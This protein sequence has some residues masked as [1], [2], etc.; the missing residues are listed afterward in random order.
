MMAKVAKEGVTLVSSAGTGYFY[1]YRQ[2]KKKGK[3]A[4]KIKVKKFDPIAQAHVWFETKKLSRLKK[5]FNKEN[6]LAA[7][8]AAAETAGE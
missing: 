6:F 1:T 7:K 5:K 4:V 2:N 8:T 3:G